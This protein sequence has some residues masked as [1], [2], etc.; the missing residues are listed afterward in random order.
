[1]RTYQ[2][3]VGYVGASVALLCWLAILVSGRAVFGG[4]NIQWVGYMVAW[5]C[6]VFVLIADRA[7]P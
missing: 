5:G 1:M 4:I 3:V 6:L 7:D 2:E